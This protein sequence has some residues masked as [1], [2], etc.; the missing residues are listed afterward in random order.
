[1]RIA[2]F[3]VFAHGQRQRRV[4]HG[5]QNVDEGDLADDDAKKIRAHVRHRAHQEPA[6]A[7]SLNDD[8]FRRCVAL[9]DEVFGRGDEVRERVALV[10]HAAGVV[11]RLSEFAATSNVRNRVDHTTVQQAE[12]V[13]TE[14]YG[15]GNSVAAVSIEKERG[16][17]IERRIAAVDHRKRHTRAFGSRGMQPLADILRR[18][19]PAKNGLLLPQASFPRANFVVIDGARSHERFVL[20]S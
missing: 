17:T 8:P 7:S 11:P 18:I 6:G 15:H 13:R 12:P 14:I 2:P 10:F 19:V 20:E 16:R 5:V 1:M 4:E 9:R 3:L